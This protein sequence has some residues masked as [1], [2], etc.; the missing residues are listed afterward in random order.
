MYVSKSLSDTDSWFSPA[1]FKDN[2]SLD[3]SCV[4]TCSQSRIKLHK[5]QPKSDEKMG[6]GEC[7]LKD[8]L[9]QRH[10]DSYEKIQRL[11]DCFVA[12]FKF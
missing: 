5:H 10:L 8:I 4:F 1:D 9:F 12:F 3:S 6:E 2:N 11:F 7:S